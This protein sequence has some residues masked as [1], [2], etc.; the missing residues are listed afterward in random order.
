[1]RRYRQ[2]INPYVTTSSDKGFVSGDPFSVYP[3]KNGVVPS[4]RA[5]V[6]RAALTDIR[7]CKAL[8]AVIGRDKVIKMIDEAAG[9]NI[10]FSEYP[11]NSEFILELIEKMKKM[12]KKYAV[13]EN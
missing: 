6:F 1:M 10:T 12:L 9:M 8:E 7:V 11:K 13:V 5:I 3:V 2:L 4:L